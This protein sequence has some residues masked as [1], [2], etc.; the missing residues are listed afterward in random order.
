MVAT[1]TVRCLLLEIDRRDVL[2]PNQLVEVLDAGCLNLVQV[3]Q[4]HLQL[5][6]QLIEDRDRLCCEQGQ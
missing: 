3:I 4:F 1:V 6:G 5:R 2:I